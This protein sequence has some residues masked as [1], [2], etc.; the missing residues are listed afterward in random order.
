MF[1]GWCFTSNLAH[2][3]NGRIIIAWNPNSY[4]I[5]I[6]GGTSQFIHSRIRSKRGTQFAITVVYAL[7]DSN[8]RQKL[9]NDLGLIAHGTKIPWIVCGDFNSILST[10][11]SLDYR[12]NGNEMVPFQTCT[13]KQEGKDRVCAKLDRVLANNDWLDKFP[14]AEVSFLPEGVFDH[15]PALLFIYPNIHDQ[16]KPFRYFSYWSSLKEFNGIVQTGWL[17]NV[18]GSQM[19]RIVNKLR[20]LKHGL[21]GLNQQ[22]K[23][24]IG[25]QDTE[26]FKALINI[27]MALR[28]Q[29]GNGDLIAQEIQAR[30]HYAETRKQYL[31]FLRQKPKITWLAYG[32]DNTKKFHASIKQRRLQ[33][34]I[35]S[36][37]KT[38]GTW[39]TKKNEVIRAFLAFYENLL[40]SKMNT[41]TWVHKSIVHE[42]PVVSPNQVA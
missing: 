37:K 23:R 24:D 21:R 20:H 28:E 13:N 1:Q 42:G 36:V 27:Q 11:E 4:E 34:T 12:G 40:G 18:E 5:D 22:G 19:Y 8:G 16:R 10:E 9:W 17:E 14:T 7:N 30:N 2:H 29:P 32:N 31:N 35:Y 15:S 26:A 6:K 39:V 38:N 3:H 33:N 41:R 25:I